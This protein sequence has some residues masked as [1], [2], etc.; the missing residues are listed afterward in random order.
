MNLLVRIS[1]VAVINEMFNIFLI[2][3]AAA[4]IFYVILFI[5]SFFAFRSGFVP[6]KEIAKGKVSKRW[7][8]YKDQLESNYNELENLEKEEVILSGYKKR[9]IS[10]HFIKSS[11]NSKKVVIFSH[12]WKNTGLNDYSSAGMFWHRN[13]FNVLII[14]HQAHGKSEGKYIG[15]GGDSD[16]YNLRCWINYLNTKFDNQCE[17]YLHGVS[18]GATTVLGVASEKIDNLKGIIAD[19]CY[20]SAYNQCKHV[21]KRQYKLLGNIISFNIRIYARIVA[22]CKFK[23]CDVRNSLIY[24]KYPILFLHGEKDDFVPTSNSIECYNLCTSDKEIVIYD[25]AT[26]IMA[27]MMYQRKYEEDLLKFIEKQTNC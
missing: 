4:I 25:D 20:K 5:I 19:S 16:K 17:I 8:N 7:S 1:D 18:M 23:N 21:I 3:I 26:H 10:A 13:D 12:G 11:S 15:F 6:P 27:C 14:N 22:G 9:K 24:S 2:L